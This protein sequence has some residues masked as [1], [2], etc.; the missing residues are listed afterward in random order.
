MQGLSTAP[1][2]QFQR[3]IGFEVHSG[4]Q[5]PWLC[6][7]YRFPYFFFSHVT[8]ASLLID[9]VNRVLAIKNP[10]FYKEHGKRMNRIVIPSTWCVTLLVDLIPFFI[11]FDQSAN[12]KS[13]TYEVHQVWGIT[14][15]FLFNIFIFV[16]MVTNYFIIWKIAASISVTDRSRVTKL[17]SNQHSVTKLRRSSKHCS[18]INSDFQVLHAYDGVVFMEDSSTTSRTSGNPSFE[19]RTLSV[20]PNNKMTFVSAQ[21]NHKTKKELEHTKSKTIISD[22]IKQLRYLSEIKATKTSALLLTSYM[23]C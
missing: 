12:Y 23:I 11:P 19:T 15:I 4:S 8:K 10:Y 1:V 9:S 2:E 14:V 13:C 3:L 17:R 6:D 7:M 5:S 16:V 18:G 20:N 22:T 21:P